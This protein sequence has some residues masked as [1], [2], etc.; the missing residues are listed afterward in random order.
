ML[1][2]EVKIV[3]KNL[4]V[5]RSDETALINGNASLRSQNEDLVKRTKGLL[6]EYSDNVRKHVDKI[7]EMAEELHEARRLTIAAAIPVKT[8]GNIAKAM[9]GESPRL[10]QMNDELVEIVDFIDE[11]TP[12]GTESSRLLKEIGKIT[13]K[14]ANLPLRE[15]FSLYGIHV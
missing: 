3:Q 4:E 5:L 2:S 9:N 13:H 12:E 6:N 14:L 1:Q 7:K 15:V 8:L 11:K 10:V